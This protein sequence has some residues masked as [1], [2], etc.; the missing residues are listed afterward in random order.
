MVKPVHPDAPHPFGLLR[1]R[2]KRPHSRRPESRRGDRIETLFAAV[3]ESVG[4]QILLQKS[5]IE[6][7]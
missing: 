6:Q 4:W 7:P 2:C 5:K 3:H 1:P